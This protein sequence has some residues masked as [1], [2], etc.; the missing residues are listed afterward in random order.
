M[1]CEAMNWSNLG[2]V[3]CSQSL[4]IFR[5]LDAYRWG[6]LGIDVPKVAR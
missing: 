2:P 1:G 4:I 5:I 6:V 3:F